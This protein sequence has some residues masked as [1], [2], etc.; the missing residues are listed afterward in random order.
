ME[1]SSSSSDD[2]AIPHSISSDLLVGLDKS[3]AVHE[4][5]LFG[6]PP[7]VDKTENSGGK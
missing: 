6:V 5:P 3:L 7:N 1:W 4:G 2:K